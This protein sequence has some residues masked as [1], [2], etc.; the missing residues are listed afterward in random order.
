MKS[1]WKLTYRPPEYARWE[2][3]ESGGPWSPG[4]YVESSY[5]SDPGGTLIQSRGDLRIKV[6]PFFLPQKRFIRNVLST[7]EEEDVAF[8]RA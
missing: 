3:L 4:S 2:I 7:I 6:L 8:L 5:T 1:R